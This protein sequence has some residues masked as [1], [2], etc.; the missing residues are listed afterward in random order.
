MTADDFLEIARA[1]SDPLCLLTAQG[2]F[3]AANP[4]ACKL[5]QV[6]VDSLAGRKLQDLVMPEQLSQVT[7][8]LRNWSASRQAIP[9]TLKLC[10]AN[11]E[12]LECHCHG[13]LLSPRSDN[14]PAL[15]ILRS[16]EKSSLTGG[17]VA[18]NDKIAQ[19]EKEIAERRQFEQALR[20]SDAQVRLL[21]DSAGEAIYGI[22]LQGA[23]TFVNTTCLHFLGYDSSDEVLGKN[24]HELIHHSHADGSPYLIDTC[25]INQAYLSGRHVKAEHEVFWRRDGHAFPVEYFAHPIRHEGEIL[26]AV[27]TFQDITERKKIEAAL[28]RSQE[29]LERAQAIAHLGSWDWDL[30]N[31][32]IHWS[33]E[34]CLINKGYS[35]NLDVTQEVFADC[36]HPDDKDRVMQAFEASI[37]NPKI[38]FDIKYRVLHPNGEVRYITSKAKIYY[39]SNHKPL[40]IIGTVLDITKQKQTEDEIK[41]LN[42]ELEDRVEQRTTELKAANVHLNTSLRQLQDTQEQ[43]IQSE[44]MASLGGLVA[45]VAHEINTPVGVGVTAVSHLQMKINEYTK[46]YHSGQFT[47]DDFESLLNSTTESSE[48][49][50]NNLNRAAELI[51]SFKQV[52][53]DQTCNEVRSFNLH[54]YLSEILHSLKPKL[55]T[56]T[57]QHSAAIDCPLDI[58][59]HS[60]PGAL[61]QVMTNLIM[62]SVI[63]GFD[64]QQAGNININA[65][66]TADGNIQ[67]DYSDNGKGIS[68]ENLKKIFEP[69][70]TTRRSQ[71][72]TGL[73]MHIVYNLVTQ[74]L[75]G[76][77][78]CRSTKNQGTTFQIELAATIDQQDVP[79]RVQ[80]QG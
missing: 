74:T 50:H 3:L 68:A 22:D 9:A 36:I 64:E 60:H 79:M 8:H 21:L 76:R 17:F 52:A 24:M 4:A 40:C 7:Q 49:I 5:L 1:L 11:G 71:G 42:E 46:H 62:N 47:R 77:I 56:G 37:A 51:R 53:V 33:K 2:Q 25:Q 41:K 10:A 69:F 55:K 54:E 15:I 38:A 72:G 30:A 34:A 19:L 45:G 58:V 57:G 16:K 35:K 12:C 29:T 73:G 39:D 48:I 66:H 61:S 75:G 23:C 28:T 32:N 44:K 43:L 31:N 27:V 63:H 14:S 78:H 80:G 59:M 6:D 18:L 65:S 70:F 26:G 67:L 13:S 20:E